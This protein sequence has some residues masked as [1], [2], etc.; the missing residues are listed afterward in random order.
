[1]YC[2]ISGGPSALGI[3]VWGQTDS[4]TPNSDTPMHQMPSASLSSLRLA[5]LLFLRLGALSEELINFLGQVYTAFF[6]AEC[7]QIPP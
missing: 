4:G 5:R 7:M 1:M 2:D 6:G 3:A